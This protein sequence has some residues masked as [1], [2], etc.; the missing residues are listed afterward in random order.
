MWEPTWLKRISPI[1]CESCLASD[2]DLIADLNTVDRVFI[3]SFGNGHLWFRSY[4]GS[5][6]K[7]RS[8]GPDG[9]NQSALPLSFGAS[10][11][12]CS[13]RGYLGIPAEVPT[14][15]SRNEASR[16]AGTAKSQSEAAYEPT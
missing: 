15:Q 16:G 13:V 14:A 10:L 7:I 11:R 12:S 2:G 1:P 6:S 8:A 4:G 5:L 3:H 9:S